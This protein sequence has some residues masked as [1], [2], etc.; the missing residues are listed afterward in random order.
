METVDLVIKI[1]FLCMTLKKISDLNQGNEN[2]FKIKGFV[3]WK[4]TLLFSFTLITRWICIL[5]TLSRTGCFW[6]ALESLSIR[7]AREHVGAVV[8]SPAQGWPC[9]GSKTFSATFSPQAKP[10]FHHP[11]NKRRQTPQRVGVGP[12]ECSPCA[13]CGLVNA[14]PAGEEGGMSSGWLHVSSLLGWRW[15]CL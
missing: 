12:F 9:L 13:A 1:P 7:E 8:T 5:C 3:L 11:Q 4:Q 2:N 14:T 10:L 15:P 6:R